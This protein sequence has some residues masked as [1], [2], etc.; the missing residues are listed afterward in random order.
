MGMSS[1][2][3]PLPMRSFAVPIHTPAEITIVDIAG[4]EMVRDVSEVHLEAFSGYLNARLGVGYAGALIDWFANEQNAI[5][6]A[7]VDRHRRVIGYAI[8]APSN[9][10]R[11]QRRD[12]FWVT[13]RSIILRP[14]LIFDMRLWKV[15]KVRL[16]NIV[17]PRAFRP[18][19]DL[20]EAT[21]SLV[22]IG[23]AL[24]HRKMGVGLQLLQAFEEK[25]RAMRIR[26]LSLWVLEKEM[27][28]RRLYEKCGWHLCHDA[29]GVTGVT[30]Y[31]RL[32]DHQCESM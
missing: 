3:T 17:A 13:A 12:M 20:P 30:Q 4:S 25:A 14:W 23:V 15:G 32:L 26:S 27:A 7:A 1:P 10:V 6:I 31:V 22:G 19:S 29:Q 18:L 24:S 8:G 9:L 5:A 2:L 11:R 16:R 28:T 21:M